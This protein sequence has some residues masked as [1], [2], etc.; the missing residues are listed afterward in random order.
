MTQ[1][2]GAFTILLFEL[3][4]GSFLT[5]TAGIFRTAVTAAATTAAAGMPGS[6]TRF[7]GTFF[8]G[9]E[10]FAAS[11]IHIVQLGSRGNNSRRHTAA[12]RTAG[13]RLIILQ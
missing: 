11:G 4:R 12:F 3:W 6:Y 1:H 7:V 13:R 10:G 8:I 9:L 5:I 2:P